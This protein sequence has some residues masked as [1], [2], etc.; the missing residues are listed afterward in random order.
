MKELLKSLLVTLLTT[1][2][3]LLCAE[4]AF[5]VFSGKHVFALTRYRAASVVYDEFPKDVASYN[6][7]LGWQMNPGVR[8]PELN[9]IDHGVRRNNANDD[10]L[11]G[12]GILIA[13]AS[14]TFGSGVKDE[15]AW[16]AQLEE[17]IGQPVVNGAVGNFGIDQIVLRA[18]ELLPIVKPKVIVI[19]LVQDNI[20]TAG[21]SYNGYPKP[22]FTVEDGRLVLHNN[23]VPRY[24]PRD[25]PYESLKNI[26]SYSLMIDRV[27]A[28][29]FPDSWYSSR[30]QKFTRANND[31]VNVSC[32]LLQRLKKEADD[33]GIRLLITM[34]YGGGTI[35]NTSAPDGNVTLV[36]EC[37]ARLGIQYL[38]EFSTLKELSR[39]NSDEFRSL[40]VIKNGILG[41]KSRTGNRKVAQSVAEALATKFIPA[42]VPPAAQPQVASEVTTATQPILDA[43]DLSTIFQSSAVARIVSD[44]TQSG[45]PFYRLIAAG[46]LGEH[47]VAAGVPGSADR[48]RLA[49]EAS[50]GTASRIKLQLLSTRTEGAVYGVIGDFDLQRV[51]A[52]HS[53]IG[54]AANIGSGID[55]IGDGWYRAWVTTTLPPGDNQMSIVIQMANG[56]GEFVFEPDADSIRIRNVKVE[57]NDN[58]QTVNSNLRV[59]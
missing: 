29:Y 12:G 10:H 28:T 9:T 53:R 46:D 2:I 5:G 37:I 19:D 32:L 8:T 17:M 48:L 42:G 57:R 14:F 11:R 26:L 27:M 22:Y 56:R 30:T 31:E 54:L 23:P 51:S 49:V 3:A 15:D 58:R 40:Y 13:G 21:Y 38:D 35:T 50:A 52:G 20:A 24:E 44:K 4:A 6:P 25:D 18:E 47:Y 55:P 7:L 59:Q 41:H 45:Q 16:P 34:Q 36:A 1:V 43:D 39:K 33:A